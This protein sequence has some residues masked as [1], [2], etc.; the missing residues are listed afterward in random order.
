MAGV[1]EGARLEIAL[2]VCEGVVQISI[3]S[4]PPR[5]HLATRL[6]PRNIAVLEWLF[7]ER[8]LLAQPG[9]G[10]SDKRYL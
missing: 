8:E 2:T 4:T 9:A 10:P 3:I 7:P 5:E 1:V 6:E